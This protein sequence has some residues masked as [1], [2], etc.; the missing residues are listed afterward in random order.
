[1]ERKDWTLLVI[2]AAGPS[3]LSPVQLQKSLFLIGEN[4]RSEVG[5]SFYQFVPYNYGPFDPA[6]YADA[7]RLILENLV[8]SVRVESKTWAYYVVTT[9]GEEKATELR[10]QISP[11]AF[12]YITSVVDWVQRLSFAQLL[13]AI[14]AAYPKYKANSVFVRQ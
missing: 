12:K 8:K 3:G 5:E 14:Y 7:D 6:V 2:N 11:R 13:S 1:M 4:L 10:A 9:E